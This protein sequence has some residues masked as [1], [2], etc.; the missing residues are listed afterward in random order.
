[1]TRP[2]G[3][4]RPLLLAIGGLVATVMGVALTR[5]WLDVVE[6]VGDSMAPTLLPGDLLLVE[7]WSLRR[8]EPLRG[9][10][11]LAPDPRWPA[12]VL[13]KRVAAAGDGHITLRGDNQ[14]A[15]TDS[16]TFGSVPAS[17]ARW[18]VAARYGRTSRAAS[19]ARSRPAAPI[20]PIH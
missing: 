4:S 19:P 7:S 3:S 20:G 9:E 17:S 6:V 15:S 2:R 16:A 5:R 14:A 13:V 18:R 10:V 11:V 12:R 1:M 8:R